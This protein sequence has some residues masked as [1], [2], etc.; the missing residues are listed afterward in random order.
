MRL[1][2]AITKGN[3]IMKQT[4][5]K[6]RPIFQLVVKMSLPMVL[7]MLVNALYNIVDSYFVAK[8][9]DDAFTA[10]S[11]VFPLQNLMLAV[12]CGFGIGVN[13]VIAYYLGAEKRN[14]ADKN[15][16][17]GIILNVIHGVALGVF[18]VC[19]AGTFISFFTKSADII[20]YGRDYSYVVFAFAPVLTVS[21][22]FEK[23]FQAVGKMKVSM[24]CMLVGCVTNIVLD[25]IFIFGLGLGVSGAAWATVIGQ[26]LSLAVYVIIF[27]TIK[28][29]VKCRLK[30]DAD[31]EKLCRKIYGV[32]VPAMLNMA[33]PS[34]MI[35]S[36]NGILSI[37]SESYVQI[38]G[39]Y[40]K[41]Q[42]FI[43]LTANGIVQGIR[44]LVGYNYGAG[45]NGRVLAV[46]KAATLLALGIMT[47]GTILC[48]SIP[49]QLMGLFTKNDE[50]AAGG[51]LALRIIS[52]GF[53]VSAFS[54]IISGT[55]EGLG[56]G[57]PSLAISLIRYLAII[58]IA[59]VLSR[60]FGATG[61][62]NAFWVTELVAAVT[63]F[64]LFGVF[65][66]KNKNVK[67]E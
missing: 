67:A 25:P 56:K 9:S 29:P 41:L 26:A 58:P 27:V 18:G 6:E 66:P 38:L 19:F 5:M 28:M 61:V 35:T 52:G 20:N 49:S 55:F 15:T 44:P 40:Y 37:F 47:L 57:L 65:A 32:A 36:L 2:Y 16:A 1:F 21:M 34:V 33:L 24:L 50:T 54:V 59:L 42:T 12:G 7:S 14:A 45:E 39:V 63:A 62:W 48:L 53:I 10:L 46:N 13:A 51:A 64:A 4:F 31:G 17:Y 43:Y 22:S 23:T 11:Y 60:F 30:T 8:I 3:A